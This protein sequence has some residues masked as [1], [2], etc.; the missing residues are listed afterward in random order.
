MGFNKDAT[1]NNYYTNN[2]YT[3]NNNTTIINN[4]TTIINNNNTYIPEPEPELINYPLIRDDYLFITTYQFI[5]QQY[6]FFIIMVSDRI[7]TVS[8]YAKQLSS[9][10]KF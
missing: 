8:V 3:T 9:E 5:I 2:Y 6:F 1:I 7:R 4:N 10:T